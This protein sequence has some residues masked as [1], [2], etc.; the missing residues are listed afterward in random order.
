MKT[1]DDDSTLKGSSI[2]KIMSKITKWDQAI[3]NSIDYDIVKVVNEITEVFE[4]VCE[5]LVSKEKH[6][7]LSSLIYF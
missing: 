6:K 4:N 2:Y 3:L 7:R 1:I 5:I